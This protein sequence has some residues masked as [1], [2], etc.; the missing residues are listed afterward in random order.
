MKKLLVIFGCF[1]IIFLNINTVHAECDLDSAKELAKLVYKEAGSVVNSDSDKS[2]FGRLGVA[3]VAL[4]VASTKSGS[5]YYEKLRQ[6][7]GYESPRYNQYINKSFEEVVPKNRQ[8]ESL[9]IAAL[10]LSGKFNFPKDMTYRYTKEQI[11]S[12]GLHVFQEVKSVNQSSGSIFFGYASLSDTDIFGNTVPKYYKAYY[13]AAGNLRK[14]NY[15]EYNSD[16]I[17]SLVGDSKSVTDTLNDEDDDEE[18]EEFT[19][20]YDESYE[21]DDSSGD[22]THSDLDKDK[23]DIIVDPTDPRVDYT[24]IC[25]NDGVKQAFKII[26]KIISITKIVVPMILIVLGMI[27]FAKAIFAQDDKAISKAAMSLL[28][29]FIAGIVVFF[30]PTIIY[31]ILNG[32]GVYERAEDAEN[33]KFCECSEYLFT[34]ACK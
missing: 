3:S 27:D 34:N 16:D 19:P 2:F 22:K 25:Q 7:T 15:D 10:V 32:V 4:N 29:R 13:D 9:Y 18:E 21:D 14:S 31:A 20:D 26:G 23:K 33:G 8:G 6:F 30:I 5:T 1:L 11:E 28:K 24:N 12:A 17:C